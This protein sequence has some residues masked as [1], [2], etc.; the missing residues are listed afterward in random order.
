MQA[1]EA[2]F[3]F[4]DLFLR[5]ESPP[6]QPQNL[7]SLTHFLRTLGGEQLAGARCSQGRGRGLASKVS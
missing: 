2:T 6:P 7:E 4:G 1:E 5:V 3:A